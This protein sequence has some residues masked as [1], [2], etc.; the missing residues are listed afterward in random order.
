M[1]TVQFHASSDP[2]LCLTDPDA[3]PGGPKTY[4]CGSVT[5]VKSQVANI[6]IRFFFYFCLRMEGSGAVSVLATNRSGC[7]YGRPKIVKIL[8]NRIRMRNR[9][10]NTA[11]HVHNRASHANFHAEFAN[12]MQRQSCFATQMGQKKGSELKKFHLPSSILICTH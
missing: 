2:Y 9:I 7:G 4:G 3:D 1:T 5:L 11:M 10:H 8:R 6:E 12:S